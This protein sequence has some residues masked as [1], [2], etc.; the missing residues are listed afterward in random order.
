MS[1]VACT[2]RNRV[3]S[4]L[5]VVGSQTA[6][7]TPVHSFGHNLCY[8]CPNGRC[9]P[10]LDIY[11]SKAFRWYKKNIKVRSFDPCNHALKIWESFWPFGTPTPNMGV[12][13]GVW[14]FMPSH[15][16]HSRGH[17]KWLPNLPLG[18]PPSNPLLWS[19]A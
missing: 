10:I 16:L 15:S 6:N 19:Q 17:V 12:H 9:K 14:G 3:D 11:A 1:H 18:P 5:L 7:L 8:R 4:Q 2:H 13:L